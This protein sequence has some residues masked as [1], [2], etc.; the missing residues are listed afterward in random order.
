MHFEETET[1]GNLKVPGQ[2][3]ME[4]EVKHPSQ[5][6]VTFAVYA[7]KYAVVMKDNDHKISKFWML[8]VVMNLIF[9]AFQSTHSN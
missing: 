4:C 6:V 7:K 9:P 2:A 8:Q 5:T 3:N 1:G